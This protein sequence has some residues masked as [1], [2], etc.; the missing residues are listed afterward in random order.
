MGSFF[1]S[2]QVCV[3]SKRVYVHSSIYRPFVDALVNFAKTLKVGNS[4]DEGVM[5]GPVQNE[6]Q[7]EKVKG[8]FHDSKDLTFALG[9]ANVAESKGFFIQPT[10]IDNPPDTARIVQEEPFGPIVP[11]QSYDDIEDVI[12]ELSIFR[13]SLPS[14]ASLGRA[15]PNTS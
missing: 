7:Y 6:M 3:D 12:G 5:L 15:R 14:N 8:F 1:N 10:I 2:G 13:P 9:S 4:D 11:C